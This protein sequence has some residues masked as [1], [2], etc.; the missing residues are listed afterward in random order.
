[1]TDGFTSQP[2][3][4]YDAALADAEPILCSTLVPRAGMSRMAR[5]LLTQEA[6]KFLV[7]DCPIR[8]HLLLPFIP[9]VRD[10]VQSP[11]SN[12]RA[13]PPSQIVTVPQG[14]LLPVQMFFD[15]DVEPAD[16]GPN[17]MPYISM[18]T[19]F[20]NP[21]PF[22]MAAGQWIIG[23]VTGPNTQIGIIVE[24]LFDDSHGGA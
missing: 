13:V 6:R 1:M 9:Q 11:A 18:P 5:V 15:I 20:L 21:Y 3:T 22:H 8:L 2:E 14:P 24:R 16:I 4:E 7:A 19:P 12:L 10:T 17:R 23:A